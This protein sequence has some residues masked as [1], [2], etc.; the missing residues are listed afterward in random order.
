MYCSCYC[1]FFRFLFHCICVCTFSVSLYFL[2]LLFLCM[3]CCCCCIFCFFCFFLVFVFVPF[4]CTFL[5]FCFV[6]LFYNFVPVF[7]LYL[8]V[9]L[10]ISLFVSLHFFLSICLPCPSSLLSLS[11]SLPPPQTT[12][13]QPA[14]SSK[15]TQQSKR[16]DTQI[17]WKH[18]PNGHSSILAGGQATPRATPRPHPHPP[19]PDPHR[20]TGKTCPILISLSLLGLFIGTLSTQLDGTLGAS[21]MQYYLKRD[22]DLKN[23]N[24]TR[25]KSRR[26]LLP[27]IWNLVAHGINFGTP[28]LH[29]SDI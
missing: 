29:K 28:P 26:P 12:C 8:S 23:W 16:A 1:C 10:S 5:V 24:T 11:P 14:E 25:W 15:K 22:P 7:A 18:T 9:T 17:D 4:P 6:Q 3:C 21:G 27:R 19:L 13:N 2:S 20:P